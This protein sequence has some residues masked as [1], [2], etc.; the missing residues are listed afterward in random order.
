MGTDMQPNYTIQCHVCGE[1]ADL[2]GRSIAITAA[3]VVTFGAAHEGHDRFQV[4]INLT[5]ADAS[6]PA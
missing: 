3:Q 1:Q 2:D 5:R 6:T 4:T